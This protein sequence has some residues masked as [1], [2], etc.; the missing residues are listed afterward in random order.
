MNLRA[1]ADTPNGCAVILRDLGG[2]ENWTERNHLK[3][4]KVKCSCRN[5]S[6][7]QDIVW[8]QPARNQLGREGPGFFGGQQDEQVP[9]MWNYIKGSHQHP[10]LHYYEPCQYIQGVGPSSLLTSAETK[11]SVQCPVL[12][13]PC[14][15]D[16][17][18][19]Q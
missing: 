9:A 6:M 16:L 7:H 2:L 5:N 15:K 1:V 4:N 17:D 13:S 12:G 3:F 19:V 8:G 14:M 18:V 11:P 10:G